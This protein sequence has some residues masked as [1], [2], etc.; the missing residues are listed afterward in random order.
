MSLTSEGPGVSPLGLAQTGGIHPVRAVSPGAG[1][2]SRA[3]GGFRA[4]VELPLLSLLWTISSPLRPL[5]AHRKKR[6]Q[7]SAGPPSRPPTPGGLGEGRRRWREDPTACPEQRG[8]RAPANQ[9]AAR[10]GRSPPPPPP[11]AGEGSSPQLARPQCRGR[12]CARGAAE[13]ER[14]PA[15]LY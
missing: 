3:R 4:A 6:E 13:A 8:T 11:P 10:R 2:R 14:A 9:S 5:P 15:K 12:S 1:G 7:N